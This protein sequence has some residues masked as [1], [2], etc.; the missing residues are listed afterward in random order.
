MHYQRSFVSPNSCAVCRARVK[1]LLETYGFRIVKEE[2]LLEFERSA[3]GAGLVATQPRSVH[4][5]LVV[6][7]SEEGDG[8][9]VL[10]TEVV[11]KYGQPASRLDKALWEGELDDIEALLIRNEPPNQ[12]RAKQNASA[13]TFAVVAVAFMLLLYIIVAVLRSVL[14]FSFWVELLLFFLVTL[15]VVAFY[16]LV[17]LRPR[18]FPIDPPH[19]MLGDG[20]G[21]SPLP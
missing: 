21:S 17:P 14:G 2:N 15:P 16:S 10:L 8:C 9:S 5:T 3:R 1:K 6:W 11:Q 13:G 12:D 4:T 7:L 20:K 18:N 19:W